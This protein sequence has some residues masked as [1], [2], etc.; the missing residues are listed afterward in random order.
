MSALQNLNSIFEA[1]RVLYAHGEKQEALGLLKTLWVQHHQSRSS[2]DSFRVFGAFFEILAA[3]SREEARS[4]LSAVIQGEGD[5]LGFW[6]QRTP[7]EHAVLYDW[8]GQLLL[9]DKDHAGAFENLARASSLG[10][11]QGLLWYLLAKLYVEQGELDLGLRYLRGSLQFYHQ[12]G[13]DLHRDFDHQLGAFSGKHPLGFNLGLQEFMAVLLPLTKL[14][15]SQRGLKSVREFVVEL[16]HHWPQEA[17]LKKM[18]LLLE[19]NIVG[20]ACGAPLSSTV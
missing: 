12:L 11:H 13:F 18:R 2:E 9:A 7:E 19:Q 15:K 14:A 1:A 6:M 5:F 17:R 16:I 8:M 3:E 20:A 10:R 4:L